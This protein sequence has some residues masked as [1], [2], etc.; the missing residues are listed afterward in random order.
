[1][2]YYQSKIGISNVTIV[3]SE[4]RMLAVVVDIGPYCF[5]IVSGHAPHGLRPCTI[6]W[7]SDFISLVKRLRSKAG[8]VCTR[9]N[10]RVTFP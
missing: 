4:P 6:K 5:A 7:W 3:H 9:G 8:N 10:T 2:A 1:M